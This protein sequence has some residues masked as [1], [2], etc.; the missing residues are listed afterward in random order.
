MRFRGTLALLVI[1]AALGGY[2][3]FYEYKGGEKRDKAK[4]EEN[5]L[6]KLESNSIQQIDLISPTLRITT[7]RSGDKEWRI[8]S[9]R[10]LDADSDEL[11]RIASSAADMNRESVLET[12]ATELSRFGLKPPQT[13]LEFKTKD[14]KE[15][16][17][18][19]GIKNPTGNS[20]YAAIP[21]KSEVFLVGS[22]IASTFDKK[23]EDLRNHSVLPF[24]QSETQSLDL[25]GSKGTVQLAKDDD[26]WWI[27]GKEKWA[28]DSS[29]VNGILTALSGGRIKEFFDGNPDEYT[30]L[31]F[32]KPFVDVRLVVGKNR[33]IKHLIIGTEKSMLLKKGEKK[34]KAE[35]EKK[36]DTDKKEKSSTNPPQLYLAKDESRKDL[37]F[38]EKDLVD[39]LLKSPSDFRD[40]A[41]AA[42]QRW[43]I[44]SITLTNSKGTFTFTKS[45]GDWVLGDAKK[46]TKWDA[47]NGILDALEK[48]VKEFVDSPA[49]LSTYGLDKPVARVVL[50]QG[51]TVKVDCAF[52]KETKD[53]VY[54]QVQGESSVKVADKESLEKLNKGEADFV[55]AAP[56]PAPAPAPK[57]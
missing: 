13:A 54:A 47:V 38:V 14:G 36:T 39:K 32:D 5:R 53:A 43:D 46:K 44:D 33:A 19:F 11:N 37:F 6:W 50:K 8:T 56:P 55:E 9:P 4:Q 18:N 15:Y 17:I 42:F 7:L 10:A 57:K 12:N 51:G 20:N 41:L 49:A 2:L 25:Q 40:K 23:L 30:S 16:K 35:A 52:G 26:H 29:A 34:P 1:C 48:S 45:S 21:G 27:Q 31:G 3:Y 24:E 22:Y 28:A